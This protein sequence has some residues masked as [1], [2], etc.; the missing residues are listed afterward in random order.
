MA[1]RNRWGFTLVELL[2]VVAIIGILAGLL[3]PAVLNARERARQAQCMNNQHE[4][5]LGVQLYETAKQRLPGYVNSFATYKFAWPVVLLNEIGRS[6][7]WEDARRGNVAAF[8]GVVVPQFVCPSDLKGKMLSYVGNCGM[9]DNTDTGTSPAPDYPANGVFRYL[10]GVKDDRYATTV[11]NPVMR[12][13]DMRDGAAQTLLLSENVQIGGLPDAW[14]AV[15]ASA[16]TDFGMNWVWLTAGAAGAPG[17]PAPGPG[18]DPTPP[19]YKINVDKDS[20]TVYPRPSSN[21]VGGV[22]VSYCDGH[23]QFLNE[24]IDYLTF[25]HLMTPDSAK[26]WDNGWRPGGSSVSASGPHPLPAFV[27][28]EMSQ[29]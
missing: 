26:V 27:D 2:V 29:E 20:G 1:K 24:R 23:Q 6:D 5:A 12:S 13:S 15:R 22:M 7:L 16:E 19:G 18:I 17:T 10:P 28:P 8:A 21:H 3:L 25:Q 4:L 9:P 14:Y 11:V